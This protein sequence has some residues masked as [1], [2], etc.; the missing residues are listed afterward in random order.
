M[1]APNIVDRADIA[2]PE[3]LERAWF[4]AGGR[5][6]DDPGAVLG[7]FQPVAPPPCSKVTF[8]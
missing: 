8:A 7:A 6:I 1:V 4:S 3:H 5:V 2:P